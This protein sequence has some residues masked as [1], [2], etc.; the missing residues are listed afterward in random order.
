MYSGGD[1]CDLCGFCFSDVD[2]PPIREPSCSSCGE[3]L[4]IDIF[5]DEH[6]CRNCGLVSGHI[7]L[8]DLKLAAKGGVEKKLGDYKRKFYFHEA[9]KQW[10][11]CEPS[12]PSKL[13][14]Y[15]EQAYHGAR[16]NDPEWWNPRA[17]DRSKIHALCRSI[18][19]KPV[20]IRTRGVVWTQLK[21]KHALRFKASTGKPLMNFRKFGEKWRSIIQGL[22]KEQPLLPDGDLLRF[23]C[24][25]YLK[26]EKAFSDVR[27]SKNC[28]GRPKCHKQFGCRHSMISLNYVT[29]KALVAYYRGNKE[30]LE[31]RAF[32][33]DWPSLSRERRKKI[34]LK[35]W[36]PICKA[37]G[38]I[39]N[40]WLEDEQKP[41]K[42]G[43]KTLRA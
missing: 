6:I 19:V 30:C 8:E 29:K 5:D 37:A 1:G 32:K 10:L 41:L 20:T 9:C 14:E 16:E 17:L 33:N 28:D 18:S 39:F 26:A 40:L 27:H 3:K 4:V 43:K 12:I 31:Y 34:K 13:F 25:F 21:H 38:G 24:D 7:T 35:F 42:R 23:V 36:Y 22:T 15:I 11:R 2:A